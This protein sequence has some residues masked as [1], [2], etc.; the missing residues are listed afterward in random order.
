MKVELTPCYILHRRDYRETSLI[1]E[2]LSKEHG[3]VS[4]VAKG[5]KRNKKQQ[6]VS[7]SLYQKYLMSWVSKTDLGTL[8]DVELA[9]VM[10][11]L[12]PQQMMLG[13]YVNEIV[14][15]LLHKHESHPE[16]FDAYDSTIFALSQNKSEQILLRYFE[17][18]ILQSLG[19]GVIFDQD[20]NTGEAIRAED[21]YYYK[22]DFGPSSDIQDNGLG[23]TVSGKTLLELDNETLVDS[24]NIYEA[25][26][27]LRS[28]LKQYLGDK[29]LASRQLYHAYIKSKQAV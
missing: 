9:S 14:L 1:L 29:P 18:I 28:L 3:R 21:N 19:Y 4:L 25:K 6:G 17:K 12:N 10:N 24:K 13:F 20:I 26:I 5:A 2:V 7:Y 8:I 15:R 16:L 27:L 23:V 11:P 22:L